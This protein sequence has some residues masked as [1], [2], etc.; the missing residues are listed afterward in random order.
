MELLERYAAG[1]CTGVWTDICAAGEATDEARAVVQELMGRVAR[2]VDTVAARLE[3][4]GWR[5]LNP[6]AHAELDGDEA[7]LLA[8]AEDTVGTLPLALT[9]CLAVVGEVCLAGTHADWPRTAYLFDFSGEAALADPLWLP[10]AGWLAEQC[11]MWAEEGEDEP[12]VL[13]F[14]PDELHKANISGSTHDIELP[15]SA[16]DPVLVGV[17]RRPGI[18][19]VEYLRV[20]LLQWGGFPGFEFEDDVPGLVH[21]LKTDLEPF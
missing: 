8:E 12:F 14:A 4:A 11:E 1:D 17:G 19:L 21:E 20:S 18:T 9:A 5:F 16:I 15:G 13:E 2:N 10:P 3:A 6:P 7:E